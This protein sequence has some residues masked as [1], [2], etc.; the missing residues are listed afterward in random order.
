M[1]HLP[2]VLAIASGVAL[3]APSATAKTSVRQAERACAE[4]AKALENVASAR[5][6]DDGQRL[7]NSTAQIPLRIRHEDGS[8]SRMICLLDRESGEIESLEAAE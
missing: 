2:L 8:R 1:K 4:A 3:L 6:S 5:A 7:T